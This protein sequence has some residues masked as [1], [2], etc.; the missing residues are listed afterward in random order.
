MAIQYADDESFK[1]QIKERF[2][3]VDFISSTCV[4]VT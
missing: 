3:K 1:D 2:V 4:P